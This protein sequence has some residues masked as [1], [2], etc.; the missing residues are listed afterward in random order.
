MFST[1]ERSGGLQRKTVTWL[2][3]SLEVDSC[4][5]EKTWKLLNS[6]GGAS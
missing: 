2:T 6:P 3:V 5:R 1:N 4:R